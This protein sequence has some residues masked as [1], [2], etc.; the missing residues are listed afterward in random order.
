MNSKTK[1]YKKRYNKDQFGEPVVVLK[2]IK[3]DYY[4]ADGQPVRVL[5]GIDIEVLEGEFVS[6]MGPSGSG[7]STLLNIIGALDT[8]T[9]GEYYLDNILVNNLSEDDLAIIRSLKI[10]FIF[11]TF[12]LINELTALEN[13]MLPQF[14]TGKEDK[15]KAIGL[16]ERVGLGKRIY[17]RPMELSGGQRQRVAIA[18]ALINDPAILLADEPTGNLDTKTGA[19]ILKILKEL[20]KEGKTIIMVTHDPE[21]AKI[22]DRVI[23]LKDGL[24]QSNGRK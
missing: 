22:S 14:Y 7:K 23:W 8:P 24:V 11:Q 10:G 2:D 5:K 4:L 3:K 13:V 12:N 20:H 1:T 15:G 18:R 17:H 16:L 6:I 9:E 21:I 19:Q